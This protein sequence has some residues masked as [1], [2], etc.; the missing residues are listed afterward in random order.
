MEPA[1]INGASCQADGDCTG[2]G[3]CTIRRNELN[4]ANLVPLF[5]GF[6][7]ADSWGAD[8]KP[9]IDTLYATGAGSEMRI[10]QAARF[11][12]THGV[13]PKE[14]ALGG[15]NRGGCV[16]CHSSADQWQRDDDGTFVKDAGG[17]PL[18]NPDYNPNSVAFFEGYQQPFVGQPH[19]PCRVTHYDLIKNWFA[20]FADFDGTAIWT[21][22][23]HMT[24]GFCFNMCANTMKMPYASCAQFCPGAGPVGAPT[25]PTLDTRRF[26]SVT[27]T[28]MP[29]LS[30][31]CGQTNHLH[32]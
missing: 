14:W 28:L 8:T 5:D 17:N 9:R 13:V 27:M 7:L 12:V 18:P 25:T 3:T 21:N 4:G 2:G 23:L 30:A 11:D 20:I 19:L 31:T 1:L 15:S 32:P 22:G 6:P 26:I 29:C 24:E 10:Y 16:S